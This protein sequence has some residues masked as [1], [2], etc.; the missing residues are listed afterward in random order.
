METGRAIKLADLE[1]TRT[2]RARGMRANGKK[3]SSTAKAMKPGLKEPPTWV[4]ILKSKKEGRGK[5][6]WADGSKYEGEWLDNKI[7]GY[8]IYIWTDGRK[9][10]G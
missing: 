5:Y 3:T 8:G 7:N 2:L 10:Y 4:S 9:Y 6:T 1:C